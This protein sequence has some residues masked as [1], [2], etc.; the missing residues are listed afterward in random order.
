MPMGQIKQ[1]ALK[2]RAA[3]AP[4]NPTRIPVV[5]T[6]FFVIRRVTG[7]LKHTGGF[8]SLAFASRSASWRFLSI[9]LARLV[10]VFCRNRPTKESKLS[11]SVPMGQAQLQNME[12]TKTMMIVTIMKA[13]I[14]SHRRS[15]FVVTNA[16]NAPSGST[17]QAPGVGLLQ[18]WN[19][20]LHGDC[21]MGT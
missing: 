20:M 6:P 17:N 13:I 5:A 8:D 9:I 7:Q 14:V 19:Q 18:P 16:C 4:I 21:T 10:S 2:P 11:T 3:E 12:P 15:T 1:K